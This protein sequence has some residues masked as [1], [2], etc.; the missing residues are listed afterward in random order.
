MMSAAAS[1]ITTAAAVEANSRNEDADLRKSRRCKRRS[2]HR[3]RRQ[4]ERKRERLQTENTADFT[5]TIFCPAHKSPACSCD[6]NILLK[7]N[8]FIATTAARQDCMTPPI[9]RLRL[10]FDPKIPNESIRAGKSIIS[11]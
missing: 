1:T 10:S 7:E 9:S 6:Q 11:P 8:F 4:K 3:R 5:P 2:R